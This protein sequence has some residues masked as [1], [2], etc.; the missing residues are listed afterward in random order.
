MVFGSQGLANAKVVTVDKLSNS[1]FNNFGPQIG[2]A[3]SPK[4]LNEKGVLRGGFGIGYDRLP[5]ALLANARA[6]PPNGARY[7]ICCGTAGPPADGFDTPFHNGQILYALGSDNT[8]FSYPANPNLG[9]GFD[10]NTGAPRIGAIEIYGTFPDLPNSYL[11]RWSLE[12]QYELPAKMTATIGYQGSA[13]HK[14]VRIVPEHLVQSVAN[15]D[16]FNAVFFAVP[17]VNTNYNALLARLQK[18]FSRG[19]Q[20]DFNYR[21]SKS[22]DTTSFEDP[23]G[24][25]NQTFPVDNRQERALS[26]FDVRHFIAGSA[27]WDLP[28]LREQKNWT[29]KLLGGWQISGIV[30]KHSGFPWT[31]KIDQGLRGPNGNFF[32]P[33]RPT[34]FFGKQPARNTNHDFLQPGGIFPGGGA[35]YFN[36][37]V[38]TDSTG[39]PTFQLNPPG[40]GRNVF[41]GPTYFSTDLSLAKRFGLPRLGVLGE[42]AG[43]DLRFNFFNAFNKL[44]LAPF[45]SDSPGV[46]VTRFGSL[47]PAFGEPDKALAGRVIE[48]QVRFSF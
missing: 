48:F 11:Y 21:F 43:L 19:V 18:R 33:I 40:I 47:N 14:F 25:T 42:N 20:F 28:F 8:P 12:G 31:A 16:H 4:F 35:L 41:R 37:A 46:F 5:N 22:I 17:D 6:N 7:G 38:N 3:W 27:V 32:G 29:G 26:D 9:G 13:G 2:F 15:P 36:T 30:T 10:P 34:V 39:T 45:V 23:C 1:D 44:N 24:C